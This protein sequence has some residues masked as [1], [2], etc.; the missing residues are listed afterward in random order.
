MH[1]ETDMFKGKQFN[2]GVKSFGL[3]RGVDSNCLHNEFLNQIH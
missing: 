1:K 2:I 3:K